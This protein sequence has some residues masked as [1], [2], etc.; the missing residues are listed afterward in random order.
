[1]NPNCYFGIILPIHF[2]APHLAALCSSV[3]GNSGTGGGGELG[4]ACWKSKEG[5]SSGWERLPSPTTPSDQPSAE[6]LRIPH[7]SR[8][9]D[10][11]R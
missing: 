4:Q 2:P 8:P 5:K 1:M 7:Q 10:H 11:P 3:L 9:G 6:G